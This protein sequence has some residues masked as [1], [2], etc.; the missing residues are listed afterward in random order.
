MAEKD[1]LVGIIPMADRIPELESEVQY[2]L[3]KA[4]KQNHEGKEYFRP[5]LKVTKKYQHIE[6]PDFKVTDRKERLDWEMEEIRRCIQGYDGLPGKYY[7][8]FNHVWI[9]D[10]A[11]GKIRPEFRAAD[12]DWFTFLEN[13]GPGKGAVCIKR[14][15][16]GMS[17]KA[18]V[19]VL[20]DCTFKKDFEVGMNSKTETDSRNLFKKVKYIHRSVPDFLRPVATATDR[21]DAMDFSKIV[22][23]QFGNKTRIGTQSSIISVAPT[24]TAHAGNQYG[25]LIMDESGEVEQ[26]MEIWA[27]AEDCLM[28]ETQRTGTPIIFG[29]VGDV[30]KQGKGIIEFWKR[31][32]IYDL[33]RF[34][35][36]GYN[37]LI[38]DEYGND[39]LENSIRWIIYTR[40]KK[41]AGADV[42][43]NKFKQKYPLNET[44]AFLSVSGAGVGH[45]ANLEKR[46]ASL[47]EEPPQKEKGSMRRRADGGVDFVPHPDGKVIVYERPQP[48]VNGYIASC[49]P[50]E[51]DNVV[52]TKDNSNLATVVM[53]KAFGLD[54]SRMV[55]EYE[56]R[57]LM[58]D[59]YYEQLAMILEW[60]NNCRVNVEL[61][62]G[63]WRMLDYFEDKY[64]HLLMFSPKSG[65]NARGG[66]QLTY[67]SKMTAEKKTQMVGLIDSY[68]ENHPEWIPSTRLI[69]QF[70]VFGGKGE[71]DDLAI[72]FGWNLIVL[73]ADKTVAKMAESID[74]SVPNYGYIKDGD[75]I[76]RTSNDT[77]FKGSSIK[78][79]KSSI[80]K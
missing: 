26:L 78:K 39:D 21:R 22:K 71:D 4:T 11:K 79:S 52:K 30:D 66:F 44:D 31:H 16:V 65:N 45:R 7:Y 49:D 2:H 74:R 50:A 32:H 29:T 58:L 27:N 36:W 20:H 41:E 1:E 77:I 13:L 15:Q 34:A 10:K 69:E 43:Y 48:I 57:P 70:K 25:K 3:S 23:D 33:E 73:Q 67:G 72:A 61:N 54:P 19:D 12:L 37:A 18:A 40:R 80:F 24:P 59:E 8:Y 6:Y 51:D 9:K 17:W 63:G 55:V 42:I 53:K 28:R 60:Y 56:D 5:S 76:Y 46:Y 68:T 62:K 14:R 35:F 64:H 75:R 47:I 38:M